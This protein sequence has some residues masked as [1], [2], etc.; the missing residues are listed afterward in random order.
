MSSVSVPLRPS[1]GQWSSSPNSTCI[2]SCKKESGM[3]RMNHVKSLSSDTSS[4][5][6]GE[7]ISLLDCHCTSLGASDI[8]LT[9]NSGSVQEFTG[10]NTSSS[11]PSTTQTAEKKLNNVKSTSRV[12]PRPKP[13]YEK[14]LEYFQWVD[15]APRRPPSYKSVNSNRRI[16][17]PIYETLDDNVLPGYS[18]AV[19]AITVISL[20]QEW[21]NP[22]ELSSSRA[23]KNFIME[24]NST[25]LNFY[26]IHESLTSNIKNY[27]GG[28]TNF[29]N[30]LNSSKQSTRFLPSLHSKSTY[31]FN[32]SDQQWI[33]KM[34]QSNEKKY[35]SN[36]MLFKSFSLQYGKF[37]IPTDYTK[38]TFVLRLRCE[39]QQFLINFAHVDDMIDWSVSLS[40]GID[41]SLDL[42]Y[43]EMPTYR[44][45]PRRRRRGHRRRRRRNKSNGGTSLG[46]QRMLQVGTGQSSRAQSPME[47][48]RLSASSIGA[49]AEAHVRPVLASTRSTGFVL[50]ALTNRP[51]E[52][53]SSRSIKTI[54]AK[55]TYQRRSSESSIKGIKSKLATMFHH[56][57]KPVQT[58]KRQG[59][60]A[61]AL[62]CVIEDDDDSDI[63]PL[64]DTNPKS[65]IDDK[66][67][68]S[69]ITPLK[70]VAGKPL[71]STSAGNT[72]E[73]RLGSIASTEL[74]FSK[75]TELPSQQ[76]PEFDKGD[77]GSIPIIPHLDEDFSTEN[78]LSA[79][80]GYQNAICSRLELNELQTILNEH[81]EED[82][83]EQ[84]QDQEEEEEEEEE[85]EDEDDGTE[86]A[87][88]SNE[89]PTR[90]ARSAASSIYHEEGI[91]HD[92]D[93]D[94]IY[95]PT[96][97][98]RRRTSSITS[99]LSNTPYGGDEMKWNPP[100]KEIT[101]RR[102]IRDSLRC[103][104]PLG[105]DESWVNK[106]A[107]APSM[108]PKYE[109][110]NP[111]VS[112]FISNSDL[113]SKNKFS[114]KKLYNTQPALL[115]SRCK[116]HYLTPY[117]ITPSGL[118]RAIPK[119]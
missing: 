40:I 76:T 93:D 58:H 85:E 71:F 77:L 59:S 62:N 96:E 95:V 1:H 32:R 83:E 108:G 111:P 24:I 119:E 4:D 115:L 80:T 105:F 89:L 75:Q 5:N 56:G 14:S 64:T 61:S 91:F 86:T 52:A 25:Q 110:N 57:K 99:N 88:S 116:N 90:H 3:K 104:K 43:R 70:R 53:D 7:D 6:T 54:S 11:T 112:G 30:D 33:T 2:P 35:L 9:T 94:Y 103:I 12:V 118:V 55:P 114:L 38:K 15:N 84:D 82:S 47:S 60:V 46:L 34:I 23:W 16:T 113:S 39:L 66:N 27:Y 74:E 21:L 79:Q 18:P 92:S 98:H 26:H 87:A 100:R 65:N 28:P 109:T 37:G 67:K 106:I 22:Y 102:Y 73:K 78:D 72:P 51:K 107:L 68:D 101:R 50:E 49:R 117:I 41:V 97:I 42:A 17:Y 29:P 44:T 10:T 48:R 8:S 45:V 13:N 63:D 36:D 20:K 69:P 19:K 31:Q 81:N